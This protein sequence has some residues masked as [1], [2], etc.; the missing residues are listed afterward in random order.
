MMEDEKD[1]WRGNIESHLH[2]QAIIFLY[3]LV[4][5]KNTWKTQFLNF[6]KPRRRIQ[7]WPLQICLET[8]PIPIHLKMETEEFVT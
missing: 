6:M 3:Q 2:L 8:L 7:S 1:H 4:I 5:L